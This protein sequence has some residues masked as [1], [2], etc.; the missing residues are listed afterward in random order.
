MSAVHVD[1]CA[2]GFLA[3][4]DRAPPGSLFHLANETGHSAK[5]I[6]EVSLPFLFPSSVDLCFSALESISSNAH[7]CTYALACLRLL[8]SM[9]SSAVA[10]TGTG[11]VG[12][13]PR[14]S[15]SF[16]HQQNADR[17]RPCLLP[18]SILFA[19]FAVRK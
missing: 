8:C 18:L 16:L 4:L 11:C 9:Q 6:A 1:D 5:A 14:N 19:S 12:T 2:A 13:T 3:A 10:S 7:A 17:C 15:S